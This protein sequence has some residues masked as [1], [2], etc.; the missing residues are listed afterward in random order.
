MDVSS[1]SEAEPWP[2]KSGKKKHLSEE[3]MEAML[4]AKGANKARAWLDSGFGR[5]KQV[6]PQ[7]C[8]TSVS[9]CSLSVVA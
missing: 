4:A 8:I 7:H 3:D 6:G 5:Y 9:Y 1:S 2:V